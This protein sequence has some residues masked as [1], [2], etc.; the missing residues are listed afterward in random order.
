MATDYTI[1][2]DERLWRYLKGERNTDLLESHPLSMAAT[3]RFL[4]KYDY[5]FILWL[6]PVGFI[7]I[8]LLWQLCSQAFV[9][10]ADKWEFWQ[11]IIER[12]I[13]IGAVILAALLAQH[14]F[15]KNAR[16]RENRERR[17]KRIEE[18]ITIADS[19]RLKAL[20]Y[21]RSNEDTHAE[22]FTTLMN[23]IVSART[24]SNVYFPNRTNIM[25]LF[26][27]A[28]DLQEEY[29]K[30][31]K[32]PL[33][34]NYYSSPFSI[35]N[36]AVEDEEGRITRLIMRLTKDFEKLHKEVESEH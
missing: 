1:P 18:C 9:L 13:Y 19:L 16:H 33:T 22:S 32:A 8:F 28:S 6:S 26:S 20:T 36:K 12:A 5:L 25:T 10:T 2:H 35:E 30:Y 31:L 29:Q 11:W 27:A 4:S 21:L 34:A 15:N 17:L 24:F 14:I 3:K 23:S 7:F